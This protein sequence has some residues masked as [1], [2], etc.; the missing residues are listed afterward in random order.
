MTPFPP[1]IGRAT[2]LLPFAATTLAFVSPAHGQA[3]GA[4]LP[5]FRRALVGVEVGP[6]GAQSGADVADR[7][8][9]RDFH[10]GAIVRAT[11]EAGGEYLVIWGRDGEF[12]YYDSGIE[13]KAPGLGERD[14]L[15]ET[16]EA[17]RAH[18]LPVIVYCV[19]QYPN[20]TLREHPDWK[21]VDGEG[22]PINH[23]VCFNSPYVDH[24]KG[25]L[26]EMASYDIDGFHLDMVDQGFGP[27][28][29]CWCDRCRGRFAERFGAEAPVPSGVSWNESWD[30]MLEIRYQASDRFMRELRAF[31]RE[32]DPSLTVDFNYHG[33][34]P[35]SWEVGQRPV[36]HADATDF[37]T[38]ETGMWAFGALP[39]GLNAEFYRAAKPEHPFQVVMQRG[40][41]MYHDQTTRPLVDIRWELFT[42]LAHGAF[43]TMVDKTAFDGTLDPV[44]WERTGSAFREALAMRGHFG[45]QPVAEAG[46]YYPVRSRDWIGRDDPQRWMQGFLGAHKALV[47]EHVPFGVVHEERLAPEAL[48]R[49]PVVL[50]PNAGILAPEQI[51]V[52]RAW[53]EGG[54]SLVLT[55]HTGMFGARGDPLEAGAMEALSGARLVRR[56]DSV[57][58][59]V[60]LTDA[61]T[62]TPLRGDLRP[63]WA[64]LV[65]GP[66]AVLE[67]TTA[68]PVGELLA[69]HRSLLQQAGKQ[70]TDWPMSPDQVVG[71]A[72][73]V[74]TVG[75]G[76]VLTFAC[77]PDFATASEHAIP[78]ARALL[79]HAV[80]MLHPEPRVRV[81]AP[82]NVEA[83]VTDDPS[84]RT[85][86]VHLIGYHA[87][88]QTTPPKNR[89]YVL[90]ALLENRPIFRASI[91]CRDPFIEAT[92]L[93]D[94][95]DVRVVGDRRIDLLVEDI[96]DI[97][98]IRY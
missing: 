71:P 34:P 39:V 15:R 55:G 21:A 60:R 80:R 6:T 12:T 63:D 26:R 35:F 41:R 11:V 58:N 30:R 47:H 40:V 37:V 81:E 44:T 74:N 59:W 88:P 98:V 49:F 66:A 82:V 48:E 2:V 95:T 73:L 89:P 93:D 64:F 20:A 24:V 14:V 61:P 45:H 53:V 72:A 84:T 78:E 87:P 42:L 83:V 9:S 76:K 97:V 28:H 69:P 75:R 86:R 51:A 96:H 18:E 50:I 29:G 19:L 92:A 22:N 79:A 7:V 16:T 23:L 36:Q 4:D 77:S 68:T 3:D 90:P 27:P 46:L 57:D 10:G 54:G 56:I 13:A 65:E 1:I 33:N 94:T 5:W 67:P 52:L 32:L 43:V 85:L 17:A 38:G 25:L 91:V 8:F 70:S 31:V 62:D